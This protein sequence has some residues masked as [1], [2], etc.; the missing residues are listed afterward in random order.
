MF[1]QIHGFPKRAVLIHA[2]VEPA[3]LHMTQQLEFY[4]GQ[5]MKSLLRQLKS[6]VFRLRATRFRSVTMGKRC[7]FSPGCRI[8]TPQHI[9][10]G[11]DVFI[12][13]DVLISTSASGRSPV[14]IG[15]GVMIAQRAMIIGGNHNYSEKEIHIRLQGEGKQGAI[16][17]E[18]DVWIGAGAIVL[19]GVT[20]GKGAVVSAGAVVTKSVDP[21]AIVGGVPAKKVSER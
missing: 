3:I 14:R 10:L 8:L 21:F 13:R 16:V 11:E 17:I 7:I 9:A 5:P 4:K 19:T 15:D 6:N 1:P 18:E 12:G 20:I 2:A